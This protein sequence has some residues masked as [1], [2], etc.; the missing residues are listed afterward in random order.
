MV[1][2]APLA[3]ELA[4]VRYGLRLSQAEIAARLQV[5]PSTVKYWEGGLRTPTLAQTY[6]WAAALGRRPV[7]VADGRVPV[8]LSACGPLPAGVTVPPVLWQLR[9]SRRAQDVSGNDLAAAL[10]VVPSA[11]VTW[12]TGRRHI[13]LTRAHDYAGVLLLALALEPVS[14]SVKALV[15]S[16]AR[17]SPVSWGGR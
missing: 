17:P 16:G 11:V 4:G 9:A 3:R 12:E 8:P 10:G 13:P 14:D 6:V 15:A 7:L 1:E 5:A 2:T